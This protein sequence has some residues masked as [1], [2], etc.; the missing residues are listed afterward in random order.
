MR[1]AFAGSDLLTAAA[2]ALNC[3]HGD[4]P[5]E[6]LERRWATP[7][8]RTRDVSGVSSPADRERGVR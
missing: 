4:S 5:K 6:D 8:V 2:K 7:R 1:P 3:R